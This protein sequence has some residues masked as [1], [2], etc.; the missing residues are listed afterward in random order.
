MI[1][2][3]PQWLIKKSRDNSKLHTVKSILREKGLNTVCE[4]ARCPN[5]AECFSKPTATFMIL[6]D[7]CTRRCGFCSVGKG[8]PLQPSDDEPV[9]IAEVSAKLSLRH[10]VITSVT[11]DDLPDKGSWQFVRTINEV[12]R[13]N[14][15]ITVEVLTP[16]FSGS[17]ESIRRVAEKKPEIYNH[18][19][20]T[21]PRLYKKVRPQADYRRSL[22]LLKL[23]KYFYPAII[24]KSGIMV[25]LGEEKD[26]VIGVMKDLRNAGCDVLTIGQYLMPTKNNLP[27][28]EYVEPE[29]F[30]FYKQEGV[31]MGF[32]QVESGPFVRSSYNARMINN[33]F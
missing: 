23:V 31:K 15:G 3:L 24:T 22:E 8:Y 28:I 33:K 27:V 11:R 20:E 9:K 1:S 29:I 18:N 13:L 17:V 16:D 12:R 32:K 25:G 7:V 5:I 30:E 19:I 6:G 21:V 4:S 26:E 10:V 2:R 14:N